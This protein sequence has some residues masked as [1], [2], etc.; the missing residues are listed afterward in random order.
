MVAK[1]IH[2]K[3]SRT[4]WI[5]SD[6]FQDTHREPR[7]I[8]NFQLLLPY[9]RSSISFFAPVRKIA[10]APF[11]ISF[12][13]IAHGGENL[14]STFFSHSSRFSWKLHFS[15]TTFL[16]RKYYGRQ[17]SN[18]V[19][20]ALQKPLP[21]IHAISCLAVL[22]PAMIRGLQSSNYTDRIE[23]KSLILLCF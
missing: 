20:R 11:H 5:I 8:M 18:Y 3:N 6:T 15:C 9:L 12:G 17:L 1:G 23:K 4:F 21:S 14:N 2:D 13:E 22:E 7:K 19:T 10:H 16:S